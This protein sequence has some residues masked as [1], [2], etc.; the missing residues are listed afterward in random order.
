MRTVGLTLLSATLTASAAIGQVSPSGPRMEPVRRIRPMSPPPAFAGD[1]TRLAMDL[2]QSVPIVS[3]TI[4]GK[5]P[6]RFLVDTGAGGH[7]RITP[8]L[9]EA[10]ALTPSGEATAGDG[11]GRTQTRKTYRIDSLELGQVRFSGVELSEVPLP[12]GRLQRIDGVLGLGLFAS[13]TLVLDYPRAA[14]SLS[15]ASLPAGAPAYTPDPRGLV[16][17]VSIGAET[18]PAHIDTGNALA[19]LILPTEVAERLPRRGEPR[20]TGRA[21]TAMSTMEVREVD[22]SGPVRVAGVTLPITA[23]TY[24]ALGENGNLGSKAFAGAVL[25]IDQRSRRLQIELPAPPRP[26]R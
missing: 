25:R 23:A 2:S 21:A 10:L 12:R 3:V 5:G 6:F 17:P 18:I 1:E 14:L 15:R 8:A 13:H 9:A 11:S 24:P 16:M 19:P 7:G 20:V 4:G 26:P 22:I